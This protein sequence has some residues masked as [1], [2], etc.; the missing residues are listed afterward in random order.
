MTTDLSP[1]ERAV[2]AAIAAG[3]GAVL[4]GRIVIDG[5]PLADQ[6]VLARLV[7]AG[8]LDASRRAA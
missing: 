5:L 4:G 2:L 6:F 3:R 8:I 7:A 1:R